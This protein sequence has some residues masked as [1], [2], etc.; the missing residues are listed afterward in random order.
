[1]DK[2]L[3]DRLFVPNNPIPMERIQP[4]T[5]KT[6]VG[7]RGVQ[8]R[9]P[10][11]NNLLEFLGKGLKG[12]IAKIYV[13][14]S[15]RVPIFITKTADLVRKEIAT[16]L[17]NATTKD[18]RVVRGILYETMCNLIQFYENTQLAM[19]QSHIVFAGL[20]ELS[21]QF[22]AFEGELRLMEQRREATRNAQA[23]VRYRRAR[24]EN[25]VENY[26]NSIIATYINE[27]MWHREVTSAIPLS[28]SFVK[29]LRVSTLFFDAFIEQFEHEN[30]KRIVTLIVRTPMAASLRWS[31]NPFNDLAARVRRVNQDI[32]F[33][34]R[35]LFDN[36][37]AM[38]IER[39]HDRNDPFYAE[40]FAGT[41]E[42]L[43]ERSKQ[44]ATVLLK[45]LEK[46]RREKSEIQNVSR[47]R[48]RRT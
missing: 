23:L 40:E 43:F 17:K 3:V 7:I 1:M 10:L 27:E 37:I 25:P 24:R 9:I 22:I 11:N 47:A 45:E 30:E 14:A 28:S 8:D 36:M 33:S 39:P 26:E 15:V 42:E 2:T 48:V 44:N 4:N 38:M 5:I 6:D 31:S 32:I 35:A 12:D 34:Q 46:I 19:M 21:K 18:V 41:P 16:A 29:G 20:D 13:P